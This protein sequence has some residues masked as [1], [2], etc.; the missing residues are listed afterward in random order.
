[1]TKK[2][3]NLTKRVKLRIKEQHFLLN[4][5]KDIYN[6]LMKLHYLLILF[7]LASCSV[8]KLAVS[9]LDWII[10]RQVKN[11]L[12]LYYKQQNELDK[13]VNLFLNRQIQ[14][15]PRIE[16]LLSFIETNVKEDKTT[17]T[18][19]VKKFRDDLLRIYIDIAGD[20]NSN[21]LSKN[22][23]LLDKDQ[24]SHFKNENKEQNEE[25][26]KNI[27]N[28]SESTI[29]QRMEYFV[30]EFNSVQQQIIQ[31]NLIHIRSLQEIRL[32]RRKALQKDLYQ[33]ISSSTPEKKNLIKERLHRYVR[34]QDSSEDV[35]RKIN[36]HRSHIDKMTAEVFNKMSKKQKEFIL[37]RIKFIREVI[38]TFKKSY[39]KKN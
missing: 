4:S 9:N 3:G 34:K 10:Y 19:E 5:L 39:T 20:F 12:D 7:I 17:S 22:L 27:Q 6:N 35:I 28:R 31:S 36:G 8:A 13:D 33:F 1:M 23:A 2:S 14:K 37:K 32:L 18:I 26:M 16:G 30:G 11:K 21:I 38:E 29:V 15:I 25:I 24:L